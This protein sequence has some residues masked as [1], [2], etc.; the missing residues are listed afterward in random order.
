[1]E[2]IITEGGRAVLTFS[3][4]DTW[5][6]ISVP[7]GRREAL[8]PCLDLSRRLHR[9]WSPGEPESDVSRLGR[10]RGWVTVDPRTAALLRRAVELAR[11]T[12]GCF[13][14]AVGWAVRTW[15]FRGGRER[16]PGREELR[17]PRHGWRDIRISDSAVYL[18]E[19]VVPDLGGI[20][21]GAIADALTGL[22]RRLGVDHALL[23]LGGNVALVGGREDGT[24]FRV[25]LRHPLKGRER[26]YA[27]CA[28]RDCSVVTSAGSERY[29]EAEGRRCCHLLDPAT[30][31]SAETDLL[32]V[33]V[34]APESV[35]ADGLSTACFV[36]GRA[37]ALEFLA[38]HRDR[39]AEG[40][41][42]D[43]QGGLWL[44]PGLSGEGRCT[45]TDPSV[46][47][48]PLGEKGQR[49]GE[50]DF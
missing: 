10:G 30:G 50:T 12:E 7:E 37:R 16:L 34:I 32:S 48:I 17:R 23:D 27:V 11:D 2:Q 49:N 39:G 36:A 40:A 5:N 24:P 28:G 29:V 9:L 47:I 35:L 15:N 46:H 14:P 4:F 45:V 8:G 31:W 25:G 3:A 38:R 18:P 33:T 1:M 41:L 21:K 20:A 6:R 13:D 19:D 22:L 43:R 42:L 44:T 26:Y